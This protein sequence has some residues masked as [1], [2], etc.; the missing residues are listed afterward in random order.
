M[1]LTSLQGRIPAVPAAIIADAAAT[2]CFGLVLY[3][4]LLSL[5]QR[6]LELLLL[7]PLTAGTPQ[8]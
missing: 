1:M 4:L 2:D 8:A 7:L 6:S 5:C 3:F